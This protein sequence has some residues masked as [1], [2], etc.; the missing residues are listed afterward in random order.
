MPRREDKR[1]R[2]RGLPG[3]GLN[4]VEL[5]RRMHDLAERRVPK[6]AWEELRPAFVARYLTDRPGHRAGV[7]TEDA[8][9]LLDVFINR[10]ALAA[11]PTATRCGR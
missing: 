11:G 8:N 2:R 6:E 10:P 1:R 4:Y 7:G 3:G 5:L 9:K